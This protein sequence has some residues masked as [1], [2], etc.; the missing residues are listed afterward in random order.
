M[1]MERHYLES[2]ES[3]YDTDEYEYKQHVYGYSKKG[4]LKV[5]PLQWV[6]IAQKTFNPFLHQALIVWWEE[7]SSSTMQ[8]YYGTGV[9]W[10]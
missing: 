3:Q 5:L 6:F 8:Y 4:N 7:G 1:Q 9:A 10:A 2:P